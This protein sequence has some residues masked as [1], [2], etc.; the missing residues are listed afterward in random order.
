MKSV[1]NL[2]DVCPYC[3]ANLKKRP[4]KKTKCPHCGNFIH[5]RTRSSDRKRV[6][7]TEKQVEEI[8]EQWSKLFLA[9]APRIERKQ[10]FDEERRQLTQKFGTEP[11]YNDVIWSLLNK[12]IVAHTSSQHWALYRNTLFEMGEL[13][14]SENKCSS[15]LDR[16]FE[17][18]YLDLN[19][20]SNFGDLRGIPPESLLDENGN[21][22]KAFDPARGD[23]FPGVLQRIE[24]IL[25][26]SAMMN[27]AEIREKFLNVTARLEQSLNLPLGRKDAWKTL[28]AE[29]FDDK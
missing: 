17:V 28:E 27:R 5:V 13:L 16:Y 26:G 4:Q 8:E 6:L 24:Q 1:G 29:L 12:E 20:C 9:P 2:A 21:Q 10:G 3:A 19:G 23:L 25:E 14:R 18:C 7:V 22:I 11:G 15:A